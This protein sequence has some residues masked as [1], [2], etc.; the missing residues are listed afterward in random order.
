MHDAPH[1]ML[2]HRVVENY[3]GV[4]PHILKVSLTK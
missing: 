3:V 1:C 4:V 2:M